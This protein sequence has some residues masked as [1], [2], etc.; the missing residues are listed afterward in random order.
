MLIRPCTAVALAIAL[1]LGATGARAKHMYQYTDER[2]SS[3]SPT[4]SQAAT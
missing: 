3:T 2:A 4:S 1:V